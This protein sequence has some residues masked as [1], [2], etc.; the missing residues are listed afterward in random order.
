MNELAPAPDTCVQAWGEPWDGWLKRRGHYQ[1]VIYESARE[2]QVCVC[3][4]VHNHGMRS[5]R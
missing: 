4:R 2:Y 1:Y 5:S 3:A